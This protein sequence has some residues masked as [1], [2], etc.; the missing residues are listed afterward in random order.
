MVQGKFR[1]LNTV[2]NLRQKYGKGYTLTIKLKPEC[3]EENSI[4]KRVRKRVKN[5]FPSS[6][7]KEMH[8]LLLDYQIEDNT[9][10]WSFMFAEMERMKADFPIEY[11]L[12]SDTTLESIF[13]DF[14]KMNTR[15]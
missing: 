3:L 4:L 14:A 7:L 15:R 2:Q 10:K 1:C 12:L 5:A 8:E 6:S 9:L 11:F 13:I